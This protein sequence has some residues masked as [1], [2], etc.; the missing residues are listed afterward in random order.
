MQV[1]VAPDSMGGRLS[2]SEVARAIGQ[3]WHRVRPDDE[4]VMSPMSDGGEGLLDTVHGADDREVRVEVAGPMGRPVEAWFSLRAD[5][6]AVIESAMACG[7]H[8]VDPEARDP[9]RATT[10]GVGELLDAAR[11]AGARRVLVGLGGSASVDGGAGALTALGFA[12][13]VADGSGLKIGAGDLARIDT[14][15]QGWRDPAWDELEVD[16]LADVRTPLVRAARVFGPQ[17]GATPEVVDRLEEALRRWEQ[18]VVRDLDAAGLA[19]QPGSGAA[20][21]LGFGLAAALGGRL[22]GGTAAVA[23]M[24]DLDDRLSQADLVITGEGRLDATS[25]EGKVVG[26]VLAR[27]AG[28]GRPAAVVAGAVSLDAETDAPLDDVDVERAAAGTP[29]QARA[30]VEDAGERLARRLGRG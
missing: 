7:L 17:K 25:F 30:E 15:Q 10:F 6:T 5:G 16:L 4:V 24:L 19:D 21:G 20:G 22:V 12:L 14:I 11:A 9:L 27:A 29:E 13:R 1:L 28:A 2:A 18:V 8:L 23:G 26:E 3:G